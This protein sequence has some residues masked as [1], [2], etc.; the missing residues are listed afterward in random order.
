M[1]LADTG[2]M[3]TEIMAG[4]A[5]ELIADPGK[6]LEHRSYEGAPRRPSSVHRD[7]FHADPFVAPDAGFTPA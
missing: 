4:A 1:A 5:A 7:P 3:A 2:I 6:A